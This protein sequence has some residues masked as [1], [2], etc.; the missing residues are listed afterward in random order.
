MS[1]MMKRLIVVVGVLVIAFIGLRI[2]VKI[3]PDWLWFAESVNFASVFL[4][5]LKTKLALGIGFGLISLI[6]TLG[7][8]LLL[9]KLALHK[10]AGDNVIPIG[11]GQIN[12]G[13]GTIIGVSVILCLLFST[14]VGYGATMQWETYLRFARSGD[15]S[16]EQ[17]D[18][19]NY[20][21]P[22]FNKDIAYYVFRMPFL[23]FVRG[24]F[25]VAFLFLTAGTGLI[26]ALFGGSQGERSKLKLS[27]PLRAHL[28]ALGSITLLLLAWGRVFAKYEL[29][30]TETTVRHGWVYG[31][32][33]ADAAARIPIQNV[34]M[35]IA[36]ISAALFFISI[37]IRGL[38]KISIGSIGVF[39]LVAVVGGLMYP[40]IIQRFSVEPQEFDREREYIEHNINYT[41]KAYNLDRIVEKPYKG[42]GELTLEDITQN[43]AVM[44]NI[45]LW[46]WRPLRDTFK[47]REARRPQ[48]DFVDVDIDRYVLDGQ[49]R[50]VMLSA[51]ELIFS[52]VKRES[53][54]WVNRT[55]LYTHGHGVA[56]IP[57]SEIGQGGLPNMYINDIPPKIHDPWK[58]KIERPEIY[59]GEGERV[60]FRSEFGRLPYIIVDEA[61]D[62]QEF[63][64][65]RADE[66]A[67][68][69]Y[70]GKGGVLLSSFWRRL[71]YALTYSPDMR[72]ILFSNKITDTSKILL[73][74]SVSAR[75]RSIAPF[76]KYDQDPYLVISEGKLYWIQDAYTTT[77]MYPY[78]APMQMSTTAVLQTGRMRTSRTRTQRTWGNYIRNSVKVV[79]DAYDG[80]VTYYL[81][82]GEKG[83]E[84]PLADC[85]SKMF[86][87]L[88]TDFKK[89]PNDLKKHIRY[90][91]ALFQIQANM[92]TD[93]HMSDPRKFYYKEDLWQVGTEKYQTQAGETAGE[94][95]VEPY[96]VILQLPGSEKEEFMLMLPFTP[97]AGKKNMVAWMAAK[98]DPNEDGTLGEYGNLLVYVFPKDQLI[99][100]TFQIEAYIDQK[101]EMS[102]QLS[103]WSQRGST[104]L[105]G[106][107]LAIP[108]K[109]SILYVEP[110]YLQA[111][112]AAAIPQLKRVVVAQGG[113]LE[114]GESLEDALGKL[115]GS[116]FPAKDD[117]PELLTFTETETSSTRSATQQALY[118]YD[119]LQKYLREIDAEMRKLGETLQSLQTEP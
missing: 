54:T 98:C 80:T 78:S 105:R 19:Q 45:R 14:V 108:I 101:E 1:G 15:I 65:P 5:I 11:D 64:Y 21:D 53:Q 55:F 114:W 119:K 112:Q 83:Q 17:I 22:I 95:P 49:I 60:S 96:Y 32:G 97:S 8:L 16:F 27:T 117:G 29:L 73:R 2:W 110:I 76:L 3:Y 44:E 36:I 37:F 77:H 6:L 43:K 69:T 74:R 40:W 12:L 100:G 90:P 52:K 13:R 23:R 24:W 46:D 81:M 9:W 39:I 79:I 71:A 4:T 92:Y 94:Q 25:Y 50:Q 30:A 116:P 104:V 67:Y 85:Y 111:D 57:V 35:V 48:Y 61:G 106:N 107:M 31:V 26:Y 42:T 89:M 56:M 75:V 62:D 38:T 118:Q 18:P 102:E 82:T 10:A 41:R 113:K 88:F 20:R 33:Y 47:Q 59:Y 70:T 86:P 103:L 68:T 99:D 84:D 87:D 109:E 66:D 63:D 7:N 115:Y 28:F 91:L 72:N 58:Q 51:R 93:Y 34:L